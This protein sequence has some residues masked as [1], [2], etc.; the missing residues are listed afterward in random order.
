MTARRSARRPRPTAGFT[1]V[2][3]LVAMTLMGLVLTGL[4]LLTGQWLPGWSRGLARVQ[5]TERLALAIDRMAADLVVAAFVPANVTST[6]PLFA[7]SDGAVTFV[8]TAL[9]PNARPGLEIV[10]LAPAA[11]GL[12]RRAGPYV[13]R[14]AD[15]PA[16]P[17]GAP[18]P[19]LDA[20]YRI[21]FSYAGRDGAWRSDWING[22][23]LPRAV[24]L[25]VRDGTTGRALA[26]STAVVI[27]AEV[28][29]LCV[30]EKTEKG[31]AAPPPGQVAEAPAP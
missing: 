15:A 14:P 9:G 21:A 4:A 26:A 18:V 31:C 13:P 30:T 16:Q 1:L 29:R 24:R 20:P 2:E 23:E 22:E 5:Q 19:L 25:V 11:G 6:K 27:A 10:Q 8:R 17:L 12:A 3:A 28:P 7:G